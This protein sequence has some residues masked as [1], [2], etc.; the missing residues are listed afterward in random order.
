M[1]MKK[2]SAPQK[3]GEVSSNWKL[4]KQFPNIKDAKLICL[5]I[6]TRDPDIKV[7]GPGVRREGYIVGLA[8]ATDDGFRG[9][10][11]FAH[12][13]G[14]QYDKEQVLRWARDQFSGTNPKL[15]ANILYD[16]DFLAADGVPVN[17]PLFDVQVAEPLLNEN[18]IFYNLDSLALEYLNEGKDET[19]L[20]QECA[21]RGWKGKPQE[22]LWRLDPKFVG[23]YAEGD[24]D[25]TIRVFRCQEPKL[26]SEELWPLFTMESELVPLLLAMRQEGVRIDLDKT[27]R[28]V[29]ETEKE[30]KIIIKHLKSLSGIEPDI[31]AARSLAQVFDKLG[32]SY[33]RTI[34]SDEPSFQAKFLERLEHPIGKMILEARQ[35]DKFVGTF[36]K[37]QI[38]DLQV[39]GR[40]HPSFNQLKG[41]DYGTVT[42]RF[43]CSLPNLQFIPARHP[44]L[45][46]LTRSLFIPNPGCRWGRA[47]Y[48]QI[49]IRILAHYARGEGAA[50]IRQAY[51]ENPD[52]D[53]HQW[54]ADKARVSRKHAKTINFGV[55]YGM[56]AAKLAQDLGISISEANK[57]LSTYFKELP[58]LK[59]T[60][61]AAMEVAIGRGYVK[62]ILGRRRR[63]NL[64]EPANWKLGKDNPELR[65][66]DQ[67][68]A[69]E[70]LRAYRTLLA[71]ND[72]KAAADL[73]L[74]VQRAGT[75]KAFNA[76]DQGSAADIMKK[77]MVDFWKAGLFKQLPLHLTV[78]DEL[79]VSISKG[80][81]GDKAF[82]EMLEIMAQAIPLKVPVIVEAEQGVNWGEL[83]SA[84]K[85][86]FHG[87]RET[88]GKAAA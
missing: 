77:A 46:P 82:K 5:D 52:L 28:L 78:H 56:G 41:D 68:T 1:S 65:D 9:Y 76:V 17:G 61:R 11:P 44:R 71:R 3:S 42:G 13:E 26:H 31:W 24:V 85:V 48:S 79:D 51:I 35:L 6:E 29:V 38:L 16:L 30:I 83:K 53:Y 36:L 49:E 15:G 64:W 14:K 19:L 63:F 66:T 54:G 25:R 2:S 27:E 32:I 62:T 40:L 4:P 59:Q 47:D 73:G 74:G 58:F 21:R 86:I 72:K 39:K 87:E 70:K 45:G 69:R 7:T 80:Q 33:P 8:V 50:A 43:S 23:P 34:K 12:E 88:S 60:T 67:D 55:I 81:K 18:R 75:Y 37:G 57:L 22:H 20:A 10:Y 84:G